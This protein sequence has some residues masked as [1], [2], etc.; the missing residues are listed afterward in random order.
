MSACNNGVFDT[1]KNN[2]SDIV[3]D[4]S[5]GGVENVFP[6]TALFDNSS[7]GNGYVQVPPGS[8]VDSSRWPNLRV[9]PDWSVGYEFVE[10]AADSAIDEITPEQ[11]EK[12]ESVKACV[13]NIASTASD[14]SNLTNSQVFIDA[15]NTAPSC[16]HAI[17]SIDGKDETPHDLTEDADSSWRTVRP[18]WAEDTIADVGEFLAE[19][20]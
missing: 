11:I 9:D 6:R 7:S 2:S 18:N 4:A 17:K 3:I 20:H 13:D 16:H 5:G 1:V 14:S 12:V 8:T 15:L 10:Q 19:H